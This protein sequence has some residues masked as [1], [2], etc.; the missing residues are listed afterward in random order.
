VIEFPLETTGSRAD[1]RRRRSRPATRSPT[2]SR[3]RWHRGELQRTRSTAVSQQRARHADRRRPAE[4][5]AAGRLRRARR[6]GRRA[7]SGSRRACRYDRQLRDFQDNVSPARRAVLLAGALRREAALRGGLPQFRARS[8]LLQG[9][10]GLHRPPR[11]SDG[12]SG[13]QLRGGRVARPAARLATRLSAFRWD[14]RDIHRGGTRAGGSGA[15]AVSER[16]R[17]VSL[18]VEARRRMR[19]SQGWLVFARRRGT[20]RSAASDGRHRIRDV[21]NAPVI[22]AS[23]GASTSRLGD[24]VHVSAQVAGRRRPPRTRPD[25]MDQPS[26]A[27]PVWVGSMPPST[28]PDLWGSM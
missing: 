15:L 11:G 24:R 28:A 23:A 12:Q 26:P 3:H 5:H 20:R 25:A 1:L 8:R 14:A 18:G 4:L 10:L 16:P 9:R 27:A 7:G 6:S 17:Y 21:T 22:T 19:N 2:R 13:S